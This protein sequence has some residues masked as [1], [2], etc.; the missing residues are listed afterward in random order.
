MKS[1]STKN[2][3]T[4]TL[5]NLEIFH[6]VKGGQGYK[7]EAVTSVKSGTKDTI[8]VDFNGAVFP[9]GQVKFFVGYADEK[10]T[11]VQD[12]WGNK[13]AATELSAVYAA[14]KEAPTLVSVEGK[15]KTTIELKLSE[16]VDATT[17]TKAGNIVLTDADNKVVAATATLGTDK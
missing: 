11:M 16:E 13:F 3:T 9:E 1:S 17:V 4:T 5:G 7:A 12:K 2:L 6:T 14:D 15:S 8:V 10:G